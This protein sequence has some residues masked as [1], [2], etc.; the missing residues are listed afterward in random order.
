MSE[1]IIDLVFMRM[2]E[3]LNGRESV[4]DDNREI[5][6]GICFGSGI[7][8]VMGAVFDNVGLGLSAGG[9]IGVL[10]GIMIQFLKKGKEKN[11]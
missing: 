7:G 9:V 11:Q 1:E 2:K 5:G 3:E 10:V 4:I 6:L 8:I